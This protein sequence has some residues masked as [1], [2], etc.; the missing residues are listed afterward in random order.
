MVTHSKG[1]NAACNNG[2]CKTCFS[3]TTSNCFG[4]E[5]ISSRNHRQG[6]RICGV[7]ADTSH[8]LTLCFRVHFP[9][10]FTP[11]PFFFLFFPRSQDP[12][13]SINH[14]G[15]S[16]YRAKETTWDRIDGVKEREIAGGDHGRKVRISLFSLG[17]NSTHPT[18]TTLPLIYKAEF[19]QAWYG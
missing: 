1:S 18:P 12:W 17:R 10:W 7:K 5:T 3:I 16:H 9:C 13:S 14:K 19:P 6:K 11:P 4:G 8:P 2:N 15:A